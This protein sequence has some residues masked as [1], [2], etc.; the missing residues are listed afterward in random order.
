M[1]YSWIY[2]NIDCNSQKNLCPTDFAKLY[3]PNRI[4]N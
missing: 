1:Q 3:T 2:E 4:E